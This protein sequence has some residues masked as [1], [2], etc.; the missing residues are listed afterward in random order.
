[1]WY[2]PEGLGEGDRD[3]LQ[4]YVPEQPSKAGSRGNK[5]FDDT[6]EV[7]LRES[8]WVLVQKTA[9]KELEQGWASICEAKEKG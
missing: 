9:G 2:E 8:R 4:L 1:M 3:A 7:T 6:T 5:A